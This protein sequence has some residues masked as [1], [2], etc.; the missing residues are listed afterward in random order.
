V[1]IF[2]WYCDVQRERKHI[3]NDVLDFCCGCV[4]GEHPGPA[5]NKCFSYTHNVP[6]G[7]QWKSITSLPQ[8]RAGGAMWYN[9]MTNSLIYS[10]GASR[11]NPLDPIFTIDHN[12]TWELYLDDV[13]DGWQTRPSYPRFGNHVGDATVNYLGRGERHFIVGGQL[14]ENERYGN[15]DDVYEYV[16]PLR[17]WI[18]RRK[19]P[20]KRGHFSESTV[21]YKDCGFMIVAGAINTKNGNFARTR[22]ITYY[23]IGS[24]TWTLIGNFTQAITTPV[25][26]IHDD[27][28]YCQSGPVN[29]FLSLRRKLL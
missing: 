16:P 26:A 21:V 29:N 2:P 19:L 20:Y 15:L 9:S 18:V 27:Y 7:T 14:E 22:D 24:N 1:G 17:Q 6:S 23:D 28:L 8:P 12:E 10:A 11:P 4:I 3:S 13:A 5:T 25:C